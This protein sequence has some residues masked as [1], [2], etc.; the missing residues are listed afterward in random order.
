MQ[1]PLLAAMLHQEDG[2]RGLLER[3]GVNV[4][5]LHLNRYA[6]A[7]LPA[8]LTKVMEQPAFKKAAEQFTATHEGHDPAQV[9]T[10][11]LDSLSEILAVPSPKKRTRKKSTAT[12]GVT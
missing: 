4:A 1:Q 2:L 8:L 5:G 9:S 6:G 7:R 11:I 12:Q 3:S 10:R